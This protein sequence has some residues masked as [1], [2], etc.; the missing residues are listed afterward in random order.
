MRVNAAA[1]GEMN[2]PVL[3]H[4][5]PSERPFYP[6]SNILSPGANAENSLNMS[7]VSGISNMADVQRPMDMQG[8]ANMQNSANMQGSANMQ[9]S[10]NMQG[11][12]NM[13][14]DTGIPMLPVA[15]SARSAESGEKSRD[16]CDY[17]SG[18][19]PD[20]A[21]LASGF[22]PVQRKEPPRY[23]SRDALTRGTLFPGLDLPFMNVA[24]K[25]N[26]YAGTPL[27]DLMAV[28]FTIHELGLYLDT[29]R[30]DIEAFELMRR[31]L[32]LKKEG[33]ER[34]VMMYGPLTP[35]EL[36]HQDSYNWQSGPWPWEYRE[37]MEK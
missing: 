37:G 25:G 32:T 21:P 28:E 24:N 35:I 16:G 26:P 5:S 11:S 3:P 23:N 29:H 36:I 27:G 17:K 19:L 9:N 14:K 10:A 2:L 12:A 7:G 6:A 15:L 20:C 34:F 1:R 8:S 30:K 31:L 4:G 18:I 33:R 13:Q 22:V